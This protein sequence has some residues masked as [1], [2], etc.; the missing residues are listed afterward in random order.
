MFKKIS[1][2]IA[3]QFTAFVFLLFLVNGIIFLTADYTNA[4]RQSY[5]RL[6]HTLQFVTD[7]AGAEGIGLPDSLP[8]NMRDRVRFVGPNNQVLYA[9]GLFAD[10]PL[11]TEKGISNFFLEN[12]QYSVLTTPVS[13]NGG[14]GGF[15]QVADVER[16][17]GSDLPFRVLLYVFISISISAL[18]YIIGLFFAKRSLRPATQMVEQLEQF[19]QDASHELRTPL[20]V[21]NSSLDLA[22]RT[23]KYREG[24]LS[25]KED[26]A[27]IATLV[28]RLLELAR[29]DTFTLSR[30]QVDVSALVTNAAAKYQLLARNKNITIQTSVEQ[31][32]VVNGD[33]AL[34]R[35]VL[36]NLLSNAIKFNKDN[37]TIVV[38]LSKNALRVEDSGVG[39]AADAL[40]YIFD[41]FYQADSSRAH[42]GFG[43]GLSLVKRIVQLHGWTIEAANNPNGGAQFIVHI[44][45]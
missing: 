32:I 39:I 3:L 36:V 38:S 27:Q 5:D 22:L 43:L 10:I 28:E 44:V 26:V 18:T 45:T 14:P 6:S 8:P 15:L 9:G 30:K 40:P 21:L 16:F 31:G 20:A 17:Q 25:A 7:H 35:Q 41:R 2:N 37:G 24:L 11:P 34:L 4:R 42:G 13:Y 19:T 33:A 23:E 12:D 29:L 1:R